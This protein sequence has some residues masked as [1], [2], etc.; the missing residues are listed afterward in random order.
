MLLPAVLP[1]QQRNDRKFIS[2]SRRHL[3][4][5]HMRGLRIPKSAEFRTPLSIIAKG[6]PNQ[7]A[8]DEVKRTSRRNQEPPA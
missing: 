1:A 8:I 7:L 6:D 5:R 4:H 2:P 3:S